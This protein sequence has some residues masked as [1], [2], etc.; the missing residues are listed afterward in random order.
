LHCLRAIHLQ[1]ED[2]SIFLCHNKKNRIYGF[3]TK[4]TILGENR[5]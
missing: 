1:L 3:D 4:D 5:K 2:K